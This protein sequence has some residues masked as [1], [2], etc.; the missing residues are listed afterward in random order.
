MDGGYTMDHIIEMGRKYREAGVDVFHISSGGDGPIG[1][2]S[3][4]GVHAGYQVPL[5]RAVK[6]ALQVPVIAVGNL[7]HPEVAEAT[8]ANEDAD[9]VA[10]GRGMLRDP[11]WALHAIEALEGSVMPPTPYKSAFSR[12]RRA[13]S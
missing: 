12:V 8:L 3:K 7:D 2:T 11:Y 13:M 5:A 9:L 6:Q 10:V 4:P 1:T